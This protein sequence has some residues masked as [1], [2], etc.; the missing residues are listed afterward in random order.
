MLAVLSPG[1]AVQSP[2]SSIVSH[3]DG[4]VVGSEGWVDRLHCSLVGGCRV[5]SFNAG[6]ALS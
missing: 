4:S 6:A 5:G 2:A 1:V 3:R